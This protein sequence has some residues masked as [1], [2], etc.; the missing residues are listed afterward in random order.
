LVENGLRGG[1]QGGFEVLFKLL[2]EGKGTAG[3]CGS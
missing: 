3:P 2:H 1:L